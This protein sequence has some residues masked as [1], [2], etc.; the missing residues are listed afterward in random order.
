MS[1][2]STQT[3]RQGTALAGTA[4]VLPRR[5]RFDLHMHSD[6]SDGLLS[7]DD[8]LRRCAEGGLDVVALTDHDSVPALRPGPWRL[9][10]RTIHV[11]HAAEVSGVHDGREYHLLV[12]F[13]GTVPPGFADL[14][15][16]LSAARAERYAQAAS[17]LGLDGVPP[18]DDAARRGDRALTRVH[19]SRALVDAGHARNLEDAFQ[20]FT[21]NR[22]GN[23]PLVTLDYRE[24]I[25]LA[26]EAGGLTS[27]AHPP[28]EAVRAYLPAFVH[29]GLQ[30]LEACRPSLRGS[31][32]STLHRLAHKHG[33]LVTGGSDYHGFPGQRPPGQWSFPLREALPFARAMGLQA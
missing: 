24:A 21:G 29:A 25:G 23:V 17:Q 13:P 32:R 16:Q 14:L 7:P 2:V 33:L 22:T 3:P 6:R 30:G 15:R 1:D 10:G 31:D 28:L 9:A 19:L 27:W 8:L 12:Y 20:R 11:V 26:R 5:A 18:P 4:T